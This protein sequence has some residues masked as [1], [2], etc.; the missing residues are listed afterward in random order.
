MTDSIAGVVLAAG[1][2]TRLRPLTTMR[3]K[4][5]CPVANR[6]LVDH[7]L[8]RFEG[9]TRSLAVN[10]HHHRGLLE[11]HLAGT[12]HLS[13][14][15]DQPLG[16][17]GALGRLRDW[18]DGR[19]AIVVNADTYCPS[20]V[21]RLFDGWDGERI[22]LLCPPGSTFGPRVR[23]AASLLP[24]SETATLAPVPT[25]LYERSWAR[26]AQEGRLE[27]V[28]LPGD[29]LCIDCGTPAQYLDANLAASGGES[30]IGAGAVVEGI[31][32]QS[33]VWPGA[34]VGPTE[35][36]IRA[37]RAGERVTVLVR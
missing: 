9:L 35:H 6:A 36:L 22:R 5:L 2:G 17:A 20:P 4:A 18:V 12:V 7:A 32:E 13:I 3:P 16:T 29:A 14:E 24:W 21:E 8:D 25:G 11:S 15:A 31:V 10:V 1:A 30:V 37:I 19:P 28:H 27:I 34:Q 23:V 33:V 26:A